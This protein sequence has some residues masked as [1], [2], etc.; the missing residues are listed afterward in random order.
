M[1]KIDELEKI[2][3][4]NEKKTIKW[5]CAKELLKWVADK[6]VDVG[7]SLLPLFLKIS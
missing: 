1:L 6:G 5:S 2:I 4:M 3:N 7:I